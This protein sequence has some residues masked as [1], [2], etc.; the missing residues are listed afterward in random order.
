ME[1]NLG[2]SQQEEAKSNSTSSP[3]WRTE[4]IYAK[5]NTQDAS[6]LCLGHNLYGFEIKEIRFPTQLKL[7]QN[8]F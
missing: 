4:P 8:S 1:E 5:A 6:Q 2:H 7:T 3:S